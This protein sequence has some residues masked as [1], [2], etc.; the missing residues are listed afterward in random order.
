L[1]NFAYK[2]SPLAASCRSRRAGRSRIISKEVPWPLDANAKFN[3]AG[4]LG[5][6][7]SAGEEIELDQGL[8]IY[9]RDGYPR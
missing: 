8:V 1:K 4:F 2:G 5:L 3:N 6:A 9:D 7:D